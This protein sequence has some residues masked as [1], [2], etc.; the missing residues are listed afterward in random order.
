VNASITNYASSSSLI[1][2]EFFCFYY[3][4]IKFK[5]L[6]LLLKANPLYYYKFG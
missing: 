4:G 3:K 5:L 2:E 1:I 6:L